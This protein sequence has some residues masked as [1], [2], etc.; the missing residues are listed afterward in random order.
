M[1]LN[2]RS[3]KVSQK[4]RTHHIIYEKKFPNFSNKKKMYHSQSSIL[5]RIKFNI[6]QNLSFKAI[7]YK[8]R[9][10]R[11][12]FSHFD[13]IC[14]YIIAD[15]KTAFFFTGTVGNEDEVFYILY[16]IHHVL[17]IIIKLCVCVLHSFRPKKARYSICLSNLTC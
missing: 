8:T 13:M 9:D 10:V 17:L 4:S 15:T 3:Y 6:R 2:E 12:E 11:I 7:K 14:I 1:N 5:S 16:L